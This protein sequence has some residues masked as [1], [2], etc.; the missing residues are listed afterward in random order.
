M[1]EVSTD[2]AWA[3]TVFE[4]ARPCVKVGGACRARGASHQKVNT[5]LEAMFDCQVRG[6]RGLAAALEAAQATAF[7]GSCSGGFDG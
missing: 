5:L 2:G 6:K 3:G 4:E 1:H 7:P